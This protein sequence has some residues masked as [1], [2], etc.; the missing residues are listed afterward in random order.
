MWLSTHVTYLDA[1]C[2]IHVCPLEVLFGFWSWRSSSCALCHDTM[3]ARQSRKVNGRSLVSRL[4]ILY[5][6]S[7]D[8]FVINQS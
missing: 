6:S 5:L 4:L 2:T 7:V 3:C 1:P 8:R